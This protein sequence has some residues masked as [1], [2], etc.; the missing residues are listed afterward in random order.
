MKGLLIKDFKLMKSQ[1]STLIV[2]IVMTVMLTLFQNNV[3]FVMGYL[4]FLGAMLSLGTISYDDFDNGNA[5]LFSL[6]ITRQTYVAE[7]YLYTILTSGIFWLVGFLSPIVVTLTGGTVDMGM[8]VVTAIG[9]LIVL[10]LMISLLLPCFLKFGAEKGRIVMFLC[11]GIVLLLVYFVKKL[12]DRV[13]LDFSGIISFVN[14]L[15]PEI[16]LGGSLIVVV[17]LVFVSYQISILIM[18]KKE[19]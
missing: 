17:I 15:K 9:M 1:K 14:R 12:N 4:P 16:L 11:L 19:Y 13:H 18:K 7:K 10:L 3:T 5:F 2:V 6:P 8:I